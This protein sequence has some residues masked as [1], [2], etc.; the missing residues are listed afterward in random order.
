MLRRRCGAVP[1]Q[2]R[3]QRALVGRIYC[4]GVGEL[5]VPL[6]AEAL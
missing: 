1:L 3:R 4:V 2:G 5:S 6:G